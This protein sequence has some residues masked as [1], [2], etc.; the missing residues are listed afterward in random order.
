MPRDES[1]TRARDWLA[2]D[3]DADTR[4]ELEALLDGASDELDERFSGPLEFGTAG[5]RGLLGAGESRMNRAVVR[6]TTAG[7]ARYLRERHPNSSV[8]VGY[9]GRR[10]SEIFAGDTAA[11]LAAHDLRVHMSH[12][13]CPTPI[14]AFAVKELGAAAGVMITA[15]HNPPDYNGYKVYAENGAQIVPPADSEIARAIALA[16]PADA[17]PLRETSPEH[18]DLDDRYV[19]ALL[20]LH[21]R[22]SGDRSLPIVHTSLHGVGDRLIRRVLGDAGFTRVFQVPEQAEPDGRFPT[23]AFPNPEEPGALDMALALARRENAPLVLANDPDVDR[24]AAAVRAGGGY[25]QLTGNELG[26]LLGHHLLARDSGSE[27]LVIATIVSSPWLGHIAQELGVGYAETLTGFKW[28]ANKAMELEGSGARFVFGYE[29]ALGYSVG[30][31]ARDKDG[32]GAALALA[33]MAAELHARGET[34]LDELERIARRYGLFASKQ[35]SLAFPGAAGK[36]QMDE[37]M[38]ALREHPP[39]AF[40]DHRVVDIA[41]CQTGLRASRK[42]LDLPKSNVLVF[43]L[44]GG[45]RL[46]ARPS[47]T[48]PKLKLYIDVREPLAHGEPIAAAEARAAERIAHLERA[49]VALITAGTK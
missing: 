25:R 29:E 14:V 3:P 40:A 21:P 7:L 32:I 38:A 5:L 13:V 19:D 49:V 44:E 28:I 48:E 22:D 20:A 37:R 24:L 30:T 46:I 23:V 33:V 1:L 6:R 4:R 8:V 10:M 35:R 15:S 42:P 36:A 31:V 41:D 39:A 17:V 12:G 11:V 9:D 18:F 16:P 2:H 26:V 45:H 47:G 43:D 27:R 34:L